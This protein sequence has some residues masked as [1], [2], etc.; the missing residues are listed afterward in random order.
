MK[1][2]VD[3]YTRSLKLQEAEEWPD[4]L[5]FRPLAFV[6]VKAIYRTPITPNGVSLLSLIAGLASAWYFSFGTAHAL[7]WG[8][9]WLAIANTLDCADGQLAR[10]Q[11]SGT[12]LGRIIDGCIDYIIG[13]AVFLGMGAGLADQGVPAWLLVVAAGISIALH[14]SFFDRYQRL[15]IGHARGAKPDGESERALFEKEIESVRGSGKGIF[16][17]ALI[18]LY[19]RYLQ[20]QDAG[21]GRSPEAHVDSRVYVAA[22]RMMIRSWTLLGPSTTRSLLIACAVLGDIPRFLWL[23]VAVQNILLVV[24]VVMQRQVDARLSPD[25]A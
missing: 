10:I 6:F 14:A 3:E 22:N 23:V 21:K 7:L 9:I 1:Q 25:R 18:G 13:V 16:R 17:I 2:P 19:L 4:M 11:Q 5:F 8:G 24:N 12:M 15:Y 20:L